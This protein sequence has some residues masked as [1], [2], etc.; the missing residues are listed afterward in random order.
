MSESDRNLRASTTIRLREN[1]RESLKEEAKKNQRTFN[2]E[3][4]DR[5]EKSLCSEAL[6]EKTGRD[7]IDRLEALNRNLLLSLD[8][9]D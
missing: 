3:V 7:I 8:S 4:N 5:L 1:I 2:A 6:T 9:K